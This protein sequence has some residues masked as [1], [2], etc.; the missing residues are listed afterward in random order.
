MME[1]IRSGKI[2]CVIV[3][4][5]SRLG[6]DYLETSNLIET[7]FPFMGIRFISVNDHF[8]TAGKT[9][10]NKELEVALKNL[11]NDMYARDVSRRVSVARIQDQHRGRFL[12][13]SA[14]YGYRIN[15]DDPLRRFIIDEPAAKVV[16][17]IFEMVLSGLTIRDISMG[18]QAQKL[19]IPA[20]YHCTGHLY[21][22]Q[23][24]EAKRWHV[25]TVSNIL[26]N[27]AYIGNLVQGRRRARH[28]KGEERHHTEKDEWIIIEDTHEPIVSKEVFDAVEE[29][30]AEKVKESVFASERTKDIPVRPNRFKG[31]MYC[32][33]CGQKLAYS[34]EVSRGSSL[35]RR[36]Y[37]TC[38]QYYDL[39]INRHRGI[40]I[41]ENTL[42][43]ILKD[44]I[45]EI[46]R[47]IDDRDHT[48]SFAME[49]ELK[50]GLSR[51][52]KEVRKTEQKLS[53]ID[54]AAAER[55]EA[56][57]LG[58]ISRAE[59]MAA[60]ANTEEQ[61]KVL[62]AELIQLQEKCATFEADIRAKLR[63]LLGM[64]SALDG[65]IDSELINL[66][67]DRIELY[68]KHELHITWR[69]FKS[70]FW[71]RDGD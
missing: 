2:N 66:L 68:P 58:M 53:D 25:G 37:F 42:E 65:E 67:I 55:Y 48:L 47:E 14:P 10:G 44:L 41:T 51:R 59:F 33:I 18:L 5:L 36:Y 22:E 35:E 8:D 26:H 23:E 60:K 32:G 11:V 29:I 12:G 1:D 28:Y 46:L 71:R 15:E 19:C 3:K 30:L 49:R 70:D 31:I 57:V 39:S 54:A 52:R 63:W 40:H 50:E 24:D 38:N 27:Q 62:E 43:G 13:S 4:D 7:I 56:Y 64:N 16:Q 21:R 61:R 9:N 69:F 45:G 34:S 6:R 20:Q 17:S